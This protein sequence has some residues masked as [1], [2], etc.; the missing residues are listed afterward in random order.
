M[1]VQD[2]HFPNITCPE[3][4]L[5]SSFRIEKPSEFADGQ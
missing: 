1:N 2:N 5:I 4:E 3:S